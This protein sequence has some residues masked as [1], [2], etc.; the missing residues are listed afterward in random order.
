MSDHPL[1]TK[2]KRPAFFTDPALDS[3][4]TALLEVMAENWSLKER[5]YALEKALKAD[6]VIS[7]D[8]VE[9]I[10]WSDAEKMAH[11][12]ER[13]R[14]LT[15]AFRALKGDFVGRAARVKDIDA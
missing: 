6:G 11:E 9:N 15:D 4:M 14:I 10:Q 7:D 3:M 12:T 13:Q 1:D 2:G 5:L 8:T